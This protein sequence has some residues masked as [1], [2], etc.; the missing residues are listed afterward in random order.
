MLRISIV[1]VFLS[2]FLF[3]S[4]RADWLTGSFTPRAGIDSLER[5]MI[6]RDADTG[7]LFGAQIL[8]LGDITGDGASDILVC[9][10]EGNYLFEMLSFLFHGGQAA[11]TVYEQ[12]FTNLNPTIEPIGDINNDGFVDFGKRHIFMDTVLK[13]TFQVF[14]GGPDFDDNPD[15]VINGVSS[16]ITRACDLD[17]DGHLDLPLSENI[18]GGFVRIYTIDSLRDTIP[19][20]VIPDTAKGFGRN[21]ATG[22]FNGDGY[23][24]LAVAASLNR[25]TN[26]VKFYWGGP[27]YDTIADLV[28]KNPARDIG[29]GYAQFL[30][31]VGDFNGDGF[32]DLFVADV[33]N[34]PYGIYYGGPDI[35]DKIDQTQSYL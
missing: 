24:D 18:N 26:F 22:D 8:N 23:C 28:I 5:F 15:F 31:P 17:A 2:L 4:V 12:I 27:D 1:V 11:D 35:D 7:H 19:D 9:R 32:E 14:F 30:I 25:D 6:L 21:V 10:N 20:Y 16:R 33:S 29:E 3:P 34:E 13:R